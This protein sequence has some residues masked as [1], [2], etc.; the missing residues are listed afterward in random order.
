MLNLAEWLCKV[1]VVV[2]AG[3]AHRTILKQRDA[4]QHNFDPPTFR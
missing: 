1:V 4:L 3:S 2:E